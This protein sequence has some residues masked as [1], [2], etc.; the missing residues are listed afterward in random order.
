MVLTAL[1]LFD[2]DQHAITVD[3]TVLQMRELARPQPPP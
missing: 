3:I 2:P 1:A